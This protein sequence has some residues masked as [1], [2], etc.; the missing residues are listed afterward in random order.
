M[1][2]SSTPTQLILIHC[3]VSPYRTCGIVSNRICRRP[4]QPFVRLC[5]YCHDTR[6]CAASSAAAAFFCSQGVLTLFGGPARR[7]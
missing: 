1:T 7:P 3:V 2:L 4:G 6:G 5:P